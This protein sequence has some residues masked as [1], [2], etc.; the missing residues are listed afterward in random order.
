MK[1]RLIFA[2][3]IGVAILFGGCA[4]KQNIPNWFYTTQLNDKFC[5]NAIGDTQE[6]A[7]MSAIGE[8]MNLFGTKI[9]NTDY[10]R[11]VSSNQNNS[12][13]YDRQS[14]ATNMLDEIGEYEINKV[15]ITNH[16][17]SKEYAM[18]IC[19]SKTNMVE[20]LMTKINPQ[21]NFY[22]SNYDELNKKTKYEREKELDKID[23][24]LQKIT[25]A[26]FVSPQSISDDKLQKLIDLKTILDEKRTIS[27]KANSELRPILNEFATKNSLIVELSNDE[28]ISDY[29]L[30][31]EQNTT[32]K[33]YN[34][35]KTWLVKFEG[36]LTI[37]D[38]DNK[39]IIAWKH[40][41]VGEA[42]TKESALINAIQKF[43]IKLLAD[44]GLKDG[45]LGL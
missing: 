7:K 35:T 37:N 17:F 11:K 41:T 36:Y 15:E 45:I 3:L 16:L 39:Q 9:S 33:N 28:N 2:N 12:S 26:R 38:A 6:K 40:K 29:T 22:E 19:I 43:K 25:L 27:I 13:L 5:G 23:N 24:L 44:N 30:G 1:N 21:M 42:K 20:K 18:Q 32:Y 8:L 10:L 31:L 4:S 34:K 14:T